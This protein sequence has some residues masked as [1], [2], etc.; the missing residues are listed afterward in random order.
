MQTNFKAYAELTFA[1]IIAGSS[2][3]ASKLL[4]QTLPV[5]L[6]SECS[7]IVA[8]TILIPLTYIT[9]KSIPKIDN[10]TRIVLFLQSITGIFLFRVFLFFGLKF[11]SAIESSLITSTSPAMVGLLAFFL[12]KEKLSLNRIIGIVFVV[13]G[14]LIVNVYSPPA[15]S[16]YT[17]S[18]KGNVLILIAIVGEALFSIL[19]KMTTTNIPPIYRTTIIAAFAVVLFIPCSIY[20]ILH[21]DFSQVNNT[22]FLSV[23]YYGTFVSVVSYILWFKGISKVPASNAAVFTGIMSVSSIFLSSIILKERILQSHI[24]SLIFIVFGICFSC[25]SSKN[26]LI[27]NMSKN[28]NKIE[29]PT[30]N[31]DVS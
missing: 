6:A 4:V 8:L 24:I 30:L 19:S 26:Y 16:S 18:I 10:K 27:F 9:K 1:M 11:T 14:L 22:A 12:L 31:N 2:V 25:S 7:L 29:P 17:N 5:F 28:A 21:F 23:L 3:V 13:V 20:D 15:I